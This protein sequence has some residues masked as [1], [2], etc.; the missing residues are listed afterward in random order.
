MMNKTK[1]FMT[2]LGFAFAGSAGAWTSI[3]E[4]TDLILGTAVKLCTGLGDVSGDCKTTSPTAFGDP[5][6]G[7][8]AW[9]HTGRW[10]KFEAT[11]G[12]KV[13][14]TVEA[15]TDAN[16]TAYVP[17]YHPAITVWKRPI[18]SITNPTTGA[19]TPLTNAKYAPD[20]FFAP[21][22][23]YLETG[24]SQNKVQSS[25]ASATPN[26]PALAAATFGAA[27][28]TLIRPG[29]TVAGVA[30][31]AADQVFLEDDQT[32][33][34]FPRMIFAKAAWDADGAQAFVNPLNV[35][36][37]LVIHKDKKQ[38]KVTLDFIPDETAQYEIFVGG[39]F[40]DVGVTTKAVLTAKA[41][42][43]I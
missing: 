32:M 17:G 6:F 20:H 38:G 33:I 10:G 28:K 27:N 41:T 5:S 40:P 14:I 1:M 26:L 2:L 11:K 43:G 16:M 7:G 8:Q 13:S 21:T 42:K 19:V 18:G 36:P 39:Y 9:S 30:V 12:K 37:G 24:Q 34:G 35:W 31:T 25:S 15:W 23:S 4:P 29:N 3:D 22:Q